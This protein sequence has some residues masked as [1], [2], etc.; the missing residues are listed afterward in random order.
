MISNLRIEDDSSNHPILTTASTLTHLAAKIVSGRSYRFLPELIDNAW[1]GGFV[2]NP[3][4]ENLFEVHHG[5]CWSLQQWVSHGP[6]WTQKRNPAS[7]AIEWIKVQNTQNSLRSMYPG[8]PAHWSGIIYDFYRIQDCMVRLL[9]IGR[10]CQRSIVQSWELVRQCRSRWTL[11]TNSLGR[12][13][14]RSPTCRAWPR[15]ANWSANLEESIAL[16]PSSSDGR[17]INPVLVRHFRRCMHCVYDACRFEK[18]RSPIAL[19]SFFLNFRGCSDSFGLEPP[20]AMNS[21]FT[22]T[23]ICTLVWFGRVVSRRVVVWLACHSRSQEVCA[24]FKI[25]WRRRR[26]RRRP[27]CKRSDDDAAPAYW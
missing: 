20:K 15:W 22:D 8:H 23:A 11:R 13:I 25:W 19:E 9:K 16:Q 14:L 4:L 21:N 26:R 3:W 17:S 24:Q 7:P 1:V 5:E 6:R 2:Q 27:D 10:S 18:I 12:R